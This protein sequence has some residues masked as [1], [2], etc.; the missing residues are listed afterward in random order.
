MIESTRLQNIDFGC[1]FGIFKDAASTH[2]FARVL[3]RTESL[4]KLNICNCRVGDGRLIRIIVDALVGHTT[5]D[6]LDIRNNNIT[7][8]SLDDITR[9][10]VS[11][12]LKTIDLEWNLKIFNDKNATEHFV[13]TIQQKTPSVQNLLM[14]YLCIPRDNDSRNTSVASIR[15]CLM[16]NQQLNRVNILWTTPPQRQQ[17]QQQHHHHQRNSGTMMLKV[18]QR[19]ITKLAAADNHNHNNNAVGASAIFMLFHGTSTTVGKASQTTTGCGCR[20]R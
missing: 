15:S 18:S 4:K 19:A 13:T 16:R 9:L 11:T 7:F 20:H 6:T 10:L 12:Q 8:R 3:S 17:Q 14:E 2:R 1:N 5:M